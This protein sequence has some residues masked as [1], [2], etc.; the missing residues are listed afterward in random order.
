MTSVMILCPTKSHSEALG[1]MWIWRSTA[2]LPCVIIMQPVYPACGCHLGD[3]GW[4]RGLVEE[5][6]G[7]EWGWVMSGRHVVGGGGVG[8]HVSSFPSKGLWSKDRAH[9]ICTWERWGTQKSGGRT[10]K[11]TVS[12]AHSLEPTHNYI[13]GFTTPDGPA[14]LP[15]CGVCPVLCPARL[16]LRDGGQSTTGRLDS[17]PFPQKAS[18]C[19]GSLESCIY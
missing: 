14:D 4:K 1:R 2:L 7:V 19:L 12:L 16:T 8:S 17:Y 9:R 3:E 10:H 11:P 15:T 13:P 5:G 18:I 6:S